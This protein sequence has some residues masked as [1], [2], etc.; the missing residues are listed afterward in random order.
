MSSRQFRAVTT[1]L[2][3]SCRPRARI[4]R[5]WSR[6]RATWPPVPRPRAA[7]T[8][9]WALSTERP[10][11]SRSAAWAAS[12]F[13]SRAPLLMML[14]T[15]PRRRRWPSSCRRARAACGRWRRSCLGPQRSAGRSRAR[16]R[17]GRCRGRGSS[18][19]RRA[20]RSMAGSIR[21]V[22]PKPW[23]LSQRASTRSSDKMLSNVPCGDRCR[24]Q[25]TTRPTGPGPGR[26][27]WPAWMASWR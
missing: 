24:Q 1:V 10:T 3:L 22:D 23:P 26:V 15:R 4:S 13:V 6:L 17:A 12:S 18:R 20:R 5:A 14:V 25:C 2:S 7:W 16:S 19:H 21:P 11:Q 27:T 8:A 9:S